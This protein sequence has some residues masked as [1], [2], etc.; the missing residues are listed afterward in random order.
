MPVTYPE[1]RPLSIRLLDLSQNIR[2]KIVRIWETVESALAMGMINN[3]T[4]R[5]FDTYPFDETKEVEFDE[6]SF[7]L[8]NWERHAISSHLNATDS[9]LVVA[10]GGLRELVSL[11][12]LGFSVSGVEYGPKL[13]E[14]SRKW[15]DENQPE[16]GMTLS[17]RYQLPDTGDTFDAAF[18][19]RHFYSHIIER[20][21]RI[22]L[23]RAIKQQLPEGSPLILSYYIYKGE[24]TFKIQAQIANVMRRLRGNAKERVDVGDHVDP[25]SSLFH[26]HFIQDEIASELK[27]AGFQAVTTDATWFGWTVARAETVHKPVAV[28]TT[29]VGVGIDTPVAT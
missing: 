16:T 8:E 4:F 18:I 23:L 13:F 2:H 29:N 14:E 9:I 10:A 26:H 6:Q 27:E 3:E 15:L 19:C 22:E 25:E 21:E 20:S 17:S 28:A 12:R 1:T 5:Q 24:A 7:E 11:E